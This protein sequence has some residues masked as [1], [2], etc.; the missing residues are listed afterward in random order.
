MAGESSRFEKK[1]QGFFYSFWITMN[2]LLHRPEQHELSLP[3]IAKD[4]A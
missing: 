3:F 4:F 2:K 1:I